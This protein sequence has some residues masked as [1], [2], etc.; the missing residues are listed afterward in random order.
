MSRLAALSMLFALPALALDP[1]FVWE[2]LETPHFQ[3]H[4]HQGMYRYAQKAARAAELS[5]ARLVPLL[6][7]VPDS[8][9]H[10]VVQDDTDFANGNATPLLYNLIHAFAAPPDSRSTLAD[11]DDNVYELV[12]HEYTHIL[13]L[14]TVSGVPAAVNDVFGKLWITNGSQPL[15]FIEGIATFAES[16]VSGAGRVRSSEEEMVVRAE[17]LAGKLPRI[18]ALSNL[19]LDW[20]RGFGQYTV[21]SRFLEWIRDRYGLG[22]LRDLSHDFGGR[23]IPFGMNFSASRVLGKTYLALYDEFCADERRRAEELRDQV[24]GRGETEIARLTHLGEWVRTPRWNADGS[25]LYYTNA[26]PHRRAEIRALSRGGAGPADRHV[27]TLYSDG[28]GDDGLSVGPDGQV[29]FSRAEVYQQFE[30][31]Q[32]LYSVDPASGQERRLTRGLRAR[33]P[34]VARDGAIAF[35]WRRPG[36]NTAIAELPKGSDVPRVLF[37]DASGEPVDSPRYSPDGSRVAFLHHREGAWDLRILDRATLEVSDVTHD[38]ALDRDPAWTADGKWLLFSSDRSGVYDIYAARD[39]E[40]R[41][42]TDVVLGAFEPAPSPDGKRLALVTY[43]PSGYDVGSMPLDPGS[44]R[45]VTAPPVAEERPPVTAL[46]ADEAYPSRPYSPWETLRPHFWLPF[47]AADVQGTT[48]GALTAGFDAV[49]RHEYAASAWWSLSG[50]EPGWDALYVN[51]S[52]Y[53]DLTLELTRTLDDPQAAGGIDARGFY[54][55]TAIGGSLT[56][57]FPFSQ[58][59]RSQAISLTYELNRL[60]V[61][62][63]P[64]GVATSP[65]LL[66]AATL[67]YSWSD[68]RRFVRSISPEEGGRFSAAFRFS[69]RALGSDFSFWQ[70]STTGSKYF[71]LPFATDGVP[72]HHALALRASFGV[73][74]GDLSNRHDFFLGGFQQGNPLTSVI[75]PA[76]APVRILRGFAADAFH[77]T[78]F[79]LGSAEYR[80]PIWN[81]ETGPWTLPVYLRRL[82]GAV[83]CD[84]GDAFSFNRHDFG[85]HAG[86]G[87]E[88]RAETVLGWILPV[89]LRFGCARGLERSPLA[90]LDCYAALGGIF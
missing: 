42:V 84:A 14:D 22:A 10:I 28:A 29:V 16:A 88:L 69:D 5:Y 43:G 41:Q 50:K 6:D 66:G 68:A 48:V 18:D 35:V 78:A 45:P 71:A 57:A 17:A 46:P 56:A 72:W 3:V 67:R 49:D 38:R 53:P 25:T 64:L 27:A 90:V 55:E 54:Y 51:H 15:W 21:G 60:S 52:F 36:G 81:V 24:R 44:W 47:A 59:A 34:D 12:S 73:S 76:N 70:L 61:H 9:T 4:Y 85:L 1:R 87:A 77:G 2:T 82:H 63:N 83:F 13:H 31:L 75:N 58:V 65:G 26:G 74:D 33:G 20:P 39:G 32:D 7:H 62:A 80:F 40:L 19:M 89:D 30:L 11:F 23:A 8:R 86:A 79:A 37:E